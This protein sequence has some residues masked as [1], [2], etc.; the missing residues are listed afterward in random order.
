MR[1][2]FTLR[3]RA[4]LMLLVSLGLALPAQA[5]R[6]HRS[7][8]EEAVNACAGLAMQDSC[9]F[10]TPRGHE[11]AGSCQFL[12]DEIAACVPNEHRRE[13]RG[14]PHGGREEQS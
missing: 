5:G 9:S 14:A 12:P 1:V 2:L 4:V 8:P 3:L 7:P 6:G 11:I 13:F 10:L